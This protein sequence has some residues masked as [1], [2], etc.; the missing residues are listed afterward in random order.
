MFSKVHNFTILT[1]I[2]MQR[3]S[4]TISQKTEEK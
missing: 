1:E 3:Y 4:K 2:N